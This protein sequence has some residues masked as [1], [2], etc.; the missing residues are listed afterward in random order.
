MVS[1]DLDCGEERADR[2]DAVVL[3]VENES[4]NSFKTWAICSAGLRTVG[5]GGLV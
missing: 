3:G 4:R 2:K 1:G 5:I